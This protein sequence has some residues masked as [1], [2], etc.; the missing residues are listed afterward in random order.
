MKKKTKKVQKTGGGKVIP[1]YPLWVKIPLM[2]VGG[3]IFLIILNAVAKETVGYSFIISNALLYCLLSLPMLVIFGYG[4]Y[5]AF[6]YFP[7]RAF[8]ILVLL[9]VVGCFILFCPLDVV[10]I[11]FQQLRSYIS[12]LFFGLLI[13]QMAL[14][15]LGKPMYKPRWFIFG[16]FL[17]MT[18]VFIGQSYDYVMR[19][20]APR[21]AMNCYGD[22][23]VYDHDR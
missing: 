17:F 6:R 13:G 7:R 2:L 12:L 4:I 21:Y 23:C 8:C 19:V 20:Q 9:V 11:I 3:A 16:M 15:L 1:P 22:G 18:Y 14:A 10:G 5:R